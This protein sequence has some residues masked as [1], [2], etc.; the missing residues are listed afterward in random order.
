MRFFLSQSRPF[1][2]LAVFWVALCNTAGRL[3]AV[4]APT[5]TVLINW[6]AL[7]KWHVDESRIPSNATVVN[8]SPS[9]WDEH[10][11]LI[12]ATVAVVLLQSLL[13]VGLLVQRSRMK[14]AEASQRESEERLNLATTSA[15]AG[16][17]AIDQTKTQIWLTDR[18]RQLFGFAAGESPD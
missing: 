17:W 9:L 3:E 13:I 7:K 6:H 18:A 12:I 1:A 15:G 5:K 2:Y 8:R 4:S 10:P 11:R 16:L 14:R